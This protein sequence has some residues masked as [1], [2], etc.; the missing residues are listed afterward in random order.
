M[1]NRIRFIAMKSTARGIAVV[2]ASVTSF[3]GCNL[4][5]ADASASNVS[6]S[7]DLAASSTLVG[8]H[9]ADWSWFDDALGSAQIY[10]I[11]DTG[12]FHYSKW[13]DTAAYRGHPNAA[14]F[15]YSFE[16]LPQRLSNLSDPI[17]SNLRAFLA[18]T[19]KNIVVTNFHEPDNKFKG[20]FTPQQFRSGILA[21]A[22]MVRE[23]N[24]IDGGTRITSVILMDITF[25]DAWSTSADDWW[26]NAARD[27]GQVDLI[28]GDM[29]E[30]PHATNTP[31]V[32]PGYTDGVKWRSADSLLSPLYNFAR[33]HNTSWAV[34]ELGILEDVNNPSRRAVELS[35]AVAFAKRNGAH[36]ISY[37]DNKGP[38]A[39]W[40]LSWST[41]VGVT[42]KQSRA[43]IAWKSLMADSVSVD[44]NPDAHEW[45]QNQGLDNGSIFGWTKPYSSATTVRA[46]QQ[47]NNWLLAMG[48]RLSTPADVGACNG[49]PYWVESTVRGATYLAGAQ[50]M[51]NTRGMSV[52]LV[53]REVTPEGVQVG[54]S[55]SIVTLNDTTSLSV[56]PNVNLE[57]A[58]SGDSIRMCVVAQ[59]VP[60]GMTLNVDN[61]S[62]ISTF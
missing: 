8:A 34:A 37:F 19:P 52:R 38:R 1:R 51:P 36:H 3:L 62:L 29:Y 56:L 7:S 11:F 54:F 4:A 24:A 50:A 14:A 21:L 53:L 16:I 46:I 41:P 20:R 26:P 47:S 58:R 59:A 43:A 6:A 39:N 61:F 57:A 33:R 5:V 55:Q 12:G 2:V 25:T 30:W 9:S 10:R 17:R 13:Q 44:P 31:G 27:G 18:T 23:Q 49:D 32:P 40:R 45:V 42:S 48:N 60:T 35:N 22:D 15:D 28:Q